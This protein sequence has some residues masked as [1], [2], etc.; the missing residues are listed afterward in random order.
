MNKK[1]IAIVLVLALVVGGVV[2]IGINRTKDHGK[3]K[4]TISQEQA[5]RDL[6]KLYKNVDITTASPQKAAIDSLAGNVADELPDIDT[7]Y[8]LTVTGNGDVDIEIFTSTEKGGTGTDGWLNDVAKDFNA[9]GYTVDGKTMSVSVRS[10]A[11]GTAVDYIN[12]GV[13][14]PEAYTPSN[15]LFG[16]MVAA[17]GVPIRKVNDSLIG[18]T[19]GILLSSKA[20]QT[21]NEQYGDVTFESIVKATQDGVITMGY[22]NPFSS[23]TGLNFLISTLTA[24]DPDDILSADAIAGFNAFQA[25]VPLVSFTTLQMRESA[26]SGVLDGFIM[27]YQTY[28]NDKSL[29]AYS[30]IPFGVDHNNPLYAVGVL[31]DDKEAVLEKFSEFADGASAQ[32]LAEKYGFNVDLGYQSTT[33]TPDGKTC[34][35]AQKLWKDNK[36]NGQ[37]IVAVFVVDTSGSMDGDP[38]NS[39]KSSLI[40]SINYIDNDAY[41]GLITYNDVVTKQLDIAQFDLNQKA[42]FKGAV[43]GM[44][45][46]GGTAMYSGIVVGLR[47]LE[48]AMAAHPNAKP[49]LFVLTDGVPTEWL[50]LNDVDNVIDGLNIPVYTIGYGSGADMDTLGKI[51]SINEAASISASTDDVIYKIKNLFNAEL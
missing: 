40:N 16:E 47:M 33:P 28:V 6:D 50:S 15:E 41:V 4:N 46:S 32:K 36:D 48:D 14:V 25:N 34:I 17:G 5:L 7:S 24:A 49:M 18:N 1:V 27:E 30:F 51:S 3:T 35:A 21:I 8:P 43:Q 31:S 9:Q 2:A 45:A 11:T 10:I 39:L 13:Y 12:S 23:A 20:Q 29:S 19:A 38:M 44:K 42:Y 26:E 37:E 22:T